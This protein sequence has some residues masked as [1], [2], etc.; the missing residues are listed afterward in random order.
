METY[1]I[2]CW[3]FA[4]QAFLETACGFFIA[5]GAVVQFARG[6]TLSVVALEASFAAEQQF[7]I[8]R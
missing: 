8:Y 6:A 5:S 2:S 3:K 1:F 7:S 4:F